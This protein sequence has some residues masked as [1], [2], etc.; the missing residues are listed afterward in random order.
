MGSWR[1]RSEEEQLKAEAEI[2]VA[3]TRF[4]AAECVREAEQISAITAGEWE[5]SAKFT[6][7]R[8][9]SGESRR[10]GGDTPSR[11]EC[12][13]E[14]AP[15]EIGEVIGNHVWIAT[16]QLKLRKDGESGGG[17]CVEHGG[18]ELHNMLGAR[19][20]EQLFN[21]CGAEWIHA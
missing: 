18:G 2:G 9:A 4:N 1:Q 13:V 6:A 10:I 5:W 20:A 16:A 17:V 14:R 7:E 11:G 12:G 21:V 8:E 3:A 19:E 15:D